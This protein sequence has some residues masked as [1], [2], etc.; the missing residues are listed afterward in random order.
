MSIPETEGSVEDCY[1]D[2]VSVMYNEAMID[3]DLANISQG[4]KEILA[5]KLVDIRWEE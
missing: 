5:I 4:E 1:Q 2:K 3:L